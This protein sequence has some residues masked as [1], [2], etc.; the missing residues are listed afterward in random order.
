MVAQRMFSAR[1]AL[2]A[3]VEREAKSGE[4]CGMTTGLAPWERLCCQ[5]FVRSLR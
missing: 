4:S 5:E 2:T 3:S 1:P